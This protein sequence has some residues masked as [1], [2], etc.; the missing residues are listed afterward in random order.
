MS[1][2]G[3]KVIEGW[4]K[5]ENIQV[6]RAYLCLLELTDQLLKHLLIVYNLLDELL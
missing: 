3:E 6:E 1:E 2:N 4:K 5:V